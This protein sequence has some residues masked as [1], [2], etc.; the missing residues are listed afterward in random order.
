MM[1]VTCSSDS[2]L[3]TVL[4]HPPACGS[5]AINCYGITCVT[6][7]STTV[8]DRSVD[9][10]YTVENAYRTCVS[11]QAAPKSHHVHA[12]SG[13]KERCMTV[14]QHPDEKR[15]VEGDRKH[16][17]PRSTKK[18]AEDEDYLT[19]VVQLRFGDTWRKSPQHPVDV[20]SLEVTEN[21]NVLINNVTP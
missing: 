15:P 11:A 7:V 1:L 4:E 2:H 9:D 8:Q 10:H 18:S 21:S 19:V 6:V 14:R 17:G 20:T 16:G 5:T 13:P 12:S 3:M